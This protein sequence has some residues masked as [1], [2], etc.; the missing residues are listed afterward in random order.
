MRHMRFDLR[1][2]GMAFGL[3]LSLSAA[4][5]PPSADALLSRWKN[6]M[7]TDREHS[8]MSLSLIDPGS[9][10]V[11][12]LAEVWYKSKAAG[13]HQILMRFKSPA[14]LRGVAFLSVRAQ[15][16]HGDEQWLYF[17]AYRK[18]RRLSSHNRDESFLDSDFTN[19]DISFE[20][21]D[22]FDFKVIGEKTIL[23]QDVYVVEGKIRPA[24]KEGL[25]YSKEVLFITKK[26]SLNLKTEFY[27]ASGALVKTLT[28]S[29]WKKYR[30]RWAA[31]AIEVENMKTHHRSVLRF[32]SRNLDENPSD[33]LF[34]KSELESGR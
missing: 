18:A 9:S 16:Q 1:L 5:A 2:L 32:Q 15:D 13:A 26:D 14:N 33:A 25:A 3:G 34:T 19:G 24:K 10:P 29:E 23:Q 6:A 27:D 28:V 7:Y 17:P 4:A 31:D 20:Y 12:R 22:A 11:Q 8:E 30:Q 21:E